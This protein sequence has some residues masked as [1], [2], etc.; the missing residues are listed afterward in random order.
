MP[1]SLDTSS[2]I[3]QMALPMFYIHHSGNGYSDLNVLTACFALISLKR[4]KSVIRLLC[5]K[6]YHVKV[7]VK[8]CIFNDPPSP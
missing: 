5:L 3:Y 1:V 6:E 2:N 7:L 4:S 8:L